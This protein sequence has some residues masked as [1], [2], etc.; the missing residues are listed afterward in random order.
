MASHH[1]DTPQ[2]I[3]YIKK[4]MRIVPD[5]PIKGIMF[6]DFTPLFKDPL[7]V[8]ILI[9]N[10]VH[11][12]VSSGLPKVDVIAGLDARGFL[13]GPILALRLGCAFVPIRK[14]GKLPGDVHVAR[15]VKEYGVDEFELAKDAVEKGQNVVVVDDLI[16][17]GGSA[18]AAGELV[19]L[20]GGTTVRYLFVVELVDLKGAAAL[21]APVYSLLKVEGE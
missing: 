6:Q 13:L 16:A 18:K 14:R 9:T 15:Y 4:K 11:H 2:D 3:A 7:A 8:E 21:D 10:F 17:T 1:D 12:L 19:R 20:C 5:F